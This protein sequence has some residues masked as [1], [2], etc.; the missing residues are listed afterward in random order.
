MLVDGG[1]ATGFELTCR[2]MPAAL[3]LL[4][5]QFGGSS[6]D[7]IDS[8]SQGRI[9]VDMPVPPSR[10]SIPGLRNLVGGVVVRDDVDISA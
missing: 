3:R 5:C 1:A 9:E 8:G 4:A 7:P 2:V 6:L 10:Q